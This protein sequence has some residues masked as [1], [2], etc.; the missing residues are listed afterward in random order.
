MA[1]IK[2]V[3]KNP[4]KKRTE[5]HKKVAININ[6]WGYNLVFLIGIVVTNAWVGS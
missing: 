6:F 5:H 2:S 4:V 3:I 1:S